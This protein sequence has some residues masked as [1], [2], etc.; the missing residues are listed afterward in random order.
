MEMI[1]ID[2]MNILDKNELSSYIKQMIKKNFAKKGEDVVNSNI[3]AIKDAIVG[4]RKNVT[5]ITANDLPV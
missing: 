3:N 2:L 5:E 4:L 1:I